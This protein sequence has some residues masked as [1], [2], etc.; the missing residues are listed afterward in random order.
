MI[1]DMM[2]M[3]YD[4]WYDIWYDIWYMVRYDMI[5]Y[6]TYL[7]AIWLTSGG[8]RTE[9]IYTHTVH[10]TQNT[11]HRERNIHNNRTNYTYITIEK[12]TNLGSAGRAPSLRV[13]AW[14]LPYNR[15]KSIE[16]TQRESNCFMRTHRRP[17]IHEEASSHCSQFGERAWKRQETRQ[18]STMASRRF[19]H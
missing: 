5:R 4:T 6:D 11:E 2:Y 17:D 8:S 1:Y 13:I 3:I 18:D 7:T 9:H 10:R 19:K 15:V 12:L 14:H 16:K